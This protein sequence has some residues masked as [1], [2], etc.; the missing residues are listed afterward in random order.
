MECESKAHEKAEA[1][2]SHRADSKPGRKKKLQRR[3]TRALRQMRGMH[4]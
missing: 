4:R 1:K 3:P 2:T